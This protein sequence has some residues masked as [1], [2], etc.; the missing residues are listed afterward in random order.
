M[1]TWPFLLPRWKEYRLLSMSPKRLRHIWVRWIL[2]KGQFCEK[3]PSELKWGFI[4]VSAEEIY[5]FSKGNSLL[6][7]DSSTYISCCDTSTFKHFNK[8]KS[9]LYWRG[10]SWSPARLAPSL[11]LSA[12]KMAHQSYFLLVSR[13]CLKRQEQINAA[14]RTGTAS[15]LQQTFISGPDQ[16]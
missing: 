10:P 13:R 7:S 14:W 15:A 4:S 11:N 12:R 2:N 3:S 16:Q 5:T 6:L 9:I 1:W 8:R